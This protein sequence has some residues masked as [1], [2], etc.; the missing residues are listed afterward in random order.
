MQWCPHSIPSGSSSGLM[1]REFAST[2]S[3]WASCRAIVARSS[4]IVR[5]PPPIATPSGRTQCFRMFLKWQ[6]STV[7]APE[8]PQLSV[9]WIS[10]S[11]QSTP[12]KSSNRSRHCL[13]FLT[14]SVVVVP[15]AVLLRLH[16]THTE[17][18]NQTQS[19][20][21]QAPSFLFRVVP[22][23]LLLRV[24]TSYSPKVRLTS[25]STPSESH[26]ISAYTRLV[27]ISMLTLLPR[28]F[29]P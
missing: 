10:L 19:D 16:R 21:D 13:V 2:Q 15:I 1:M 27:S 6:M 7:P 25:N 14:Q 3:P 17:S 22:S 5:R 23:L 26:V 8:S 28:T 11:S 4:L 9:R 18:K 12:S 24:S 29:T 20:K